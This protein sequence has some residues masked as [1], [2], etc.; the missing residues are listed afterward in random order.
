[1]LRWWV[2]TIAALAACLAS[3][4]TLRAQPVAVA[5]TSELSAGAAATL[6]EMLGEDARPT[7]P[8]QNV[9]DPDALLAWPLPPGVDFGAVLALDIRRVFVV[10]PAQRRTL[11]RV[12]P[13]DVSLADSYAV[14]LAATE[15]L[16]LASWGSGADL[17][18]QE[19]D[20]AEPPAEEPATPEAPPAEVVTPP[21]RPAEMA[22]SLGGQAWFG[23]PVGIRQFDPRLAFEI[24]WPGTRWLGGHPFA[25]VAVAGLGHDLERSTV[26]SAPFELT[27][28][29]EELGL[30]GGLGFGFGRFELRPFAS[31]A[32]D[33]VR[34]RAE[35]RQVP[36]M[37][38]SDDRLAVT[39]GAGFEARFDLAGPWFASASVSGEGLL[40][41]TP[42]GALG[43]RVLDEPA[44][45][46]V[47]RVSF[48]LR[49]GRR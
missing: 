1:M 22:L 15:L 47:G 48:G 28:A 23:V 16:E 30:R 9:L 34:V 29:R 43:V 17:P 39:L 7:A 45:R 49:L 37:H 32:L 35:S 25:E 11:E 5:R 27:Y 2:G 8:P 42:Y 14:A 31:I 44:M 18:A 36:V 13:A 10:V 3:A 46:W 24:A 21:E 41:R 19:P 12:L 26:L 40:G 38:A 6:E 4:G 33:W 20:V